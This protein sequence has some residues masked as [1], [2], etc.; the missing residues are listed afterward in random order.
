M[1]STTTA[2]VRECVRVCAGMCVCVY[3]RV[4]VGMPRGVQ[5]GRECIGVCKSVWI[6]VSVCMG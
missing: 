5:C 6:S 2:G 1:S 4:C 3:A